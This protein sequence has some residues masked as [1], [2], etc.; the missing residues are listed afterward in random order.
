MT[1]WT[2]L[3]LIVGI[4]SSCERSDKGLNRGISLWH[5]DPTCQVCSENTG[6][7]ASEEMIQY[8]DSSTHIL[9]LA[10]ELTIPTDSATWYAYRHFTFIS[11]EDAVL[12]GTFIP[13]WS[14][15]I[16]ADPYI[17]VPSPGIPDDMLQLNFS[18][19]ATGNKLLPFH[20]SLRAA[21]KLRCG[22]ALDFFD[23]H[24]SGDT[25]SFS[26]RITNNDRESLMVL[27]PE[28]CGEN[29]L[30]WYT[31]APMMVYGNQVVYRAGNESP[32]DPGFD[33]AWFSLLRPGK[34]VVY[35]IS[36]AGYNLPVSGYYQ[37]SVSFSGPCKPLEDRFIFTNGNQVRIWAGTVTT[38]KKLYLP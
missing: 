25:L 9:Y 7:L 35:A 17:L 38:T 14:S 10:K 20:N 6:M 18:P 32:S 22:L 24:H 34:S 21:G 5:G 28:K 1:R 16:P 12:R 2:T 29:V 3:L 8:Y 37:C 13:I 36:I 31:R 27:D 4:I 26:L 19:L 33:P 30:F 15:M 11:G 23:M